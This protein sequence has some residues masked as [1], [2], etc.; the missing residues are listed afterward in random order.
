MLSDRPHKLE[1]NNPELTISK[2]GAERSDQSDTSDGFDLPAIHIASIYSPYPC[3]LDR[4]GKILSYVA[5]SV[6]TF[7]WLTCLSGQA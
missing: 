4:A 7:G 6:F 1:Q 5:N 3:P 2:D